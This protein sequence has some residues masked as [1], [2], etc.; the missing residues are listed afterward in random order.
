MYVHNGSIILRGMNT[1]PR[2]PDFPLAAT[3]QALP[4]TPADNSGETVR[5]DDMAVL[6]APGTQLR[7]EAKFVPVGT[8]L[9]ARFSLLGTVRDW[10]LWALPGPASEPR[11]AGLLRIAPAND[12]P[13]FC[14]ELAQIQAVTGAASG[15]GA[16]RT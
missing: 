16:T 3:G 8:E 6:C 9:V 4:L 5:L 2:S 10:E 12:G 13:A 15:G 11:A 14:L 1:P 7:I